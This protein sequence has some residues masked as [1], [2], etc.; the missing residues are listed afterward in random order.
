EELLRFARTGGRDDLVAFGP[1]RVG[2]RIQNLRLVVYQEDR[3]GRVHGVLGSRV[4]DAS[5]VRDHR[6]FYPDVSALALAAR[7]GDCAP[8][9]FD[10]LARDGQPETRPGPAGREVGI[11]DARQ[12]LRSN[13]DA[14]ILDLHG[15]A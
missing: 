13:T 9:S 2:Q 5:A 10:Y 3:S 6:Q 7:E 15:Q 12:I 14:A 1:Q 11:E 8:Q 4:A